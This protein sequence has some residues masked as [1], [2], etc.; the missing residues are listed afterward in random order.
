MLY[1]LCN[2]ESKEPTFLLIYKKNKFIGRYK[3]M[4][5]TKKDMYADLRVL[6]EDAERND[7]VDFIDHEVELLSKKATSKKPTTNQKDNEGIKETILDVLSK[8][9]EP[10]SISELI[11]GSPKLATQ[12]NGNP[13]SPQ[14]MSA[15]MSQLEESN[16]VVKSKDKKRTVFSIVKK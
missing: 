4:K 2:Q 9:T 3:I 12:P 5:V 8:A 16:L 13:M 15:L 11:A 6:A 14:K 10:M 7:L 1:Y